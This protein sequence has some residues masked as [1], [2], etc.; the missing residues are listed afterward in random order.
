M[1]TG[2]VLP[3]VLLM[4]LAVAV[5]RLLER[6]L[7]ESLPGLALCAAVS[8]LLLWLAASAGFAWLYAAR[9]P[10]LLSA[11]GTAPLGGLRHFLALG[12]S[13]AL[14]WAP[15]MLLVVSTAPRRWKTARW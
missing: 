5:P 4:A 3:T 9:G 14:I 13:A 6:A 1:I 12:G 8:A 15:V 10:G 7:P 2:L 11:L